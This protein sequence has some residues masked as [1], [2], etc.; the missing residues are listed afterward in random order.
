MK[1]LWG[2]SLTRY[3]LFLTIKDKE[4]CCA[5]NNHLV[6]LDQLRW[7]IWAKNLNVPLK[8]ALA[9]HEEKEKNCVGIFCVIKIKHMPLTLLKSTQKILHF[10]PQ[11][12][13]DGISPIM[14]VVQVRSIETWS[15]LAQ[16]RNEPLANAAEWMKSTARL[17]SRHYFYGIRTKQT[18]DLQLYAS[19]HFHF[20][21]VPFLAKNVVE[22]RITWASCINCTSQCILRECVRRKHALNANTLLWKL[23]RK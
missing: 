16:L 11:P 6:S 22:H 3:M 21:E 1:R 4:I 2:S 14:G 15:A 9:T 20:R 17:A 23:L 7:R 18:F 8:S 10:R 12:F 13:V 5:R 19:V